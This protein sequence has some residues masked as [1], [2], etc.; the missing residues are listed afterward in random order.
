MMK[1][2]VDD[3]AAGGRG[4]G[5]CLA[6]VALARAMMHKMLENGGVVA[7]GSVIGAMNQATG[8]P[9]GHGLVAEADFQSGTHHPNGL[10]DAIDTRASF[11][12]KLYGNNSF[13][14]QIMGSQAVNIKGRPILWGVDADDFIAACILIVIAS[15]APF[16]ARKSASSTRRKM[17]NKL[18]SGDDSV[19]KSVLVK[20]PE[21]FFE[22]AAFSFGL[23][24]SIFFL[25]LA[26]DILDLPI[27]GGI[28]TAVVAVLFLKIA[29]FFVACDAMFK[30]LDACHQVLTERYAE[31]IGLVDLF[32]SVTGPLMMLAKI[33][34]GLFVFVCVAG[35]LARTGDN[36][37]NMF[38]SFV[39]VC[40]LGAFGFMGLAL[41]GIAQEYQ[42]AVDIIT[43]GLFKK[44]DE[45]EIQ[46]SGRNLRG[47]VIQVETR[48]TRLLTIDGV[49]V[50]IPNNSIPSSVVV[51]HS[52][53]K[54]TQVSAEML[55]SQKCKIEE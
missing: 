48:L 17:R 14:A 10:F 3:Q 43:E 26:V 22:S 33:V 32:N 42:S 44:D 54:F 5:L 50:T 27:V 18:D 21:A 8:L 1:G 55:I 2:Q 12:F 9:H 37:S 28:D 35:L 52:A 36:M 25:K 46:S 53:R 41:K 40:A 45:I 7:K 24:F 49:V 39:S 16:I 15:I 38:M 11:P 19:F 23:C 47:R 20:L 51:N 4:Q 34:L 29:F 6:A 31:P 30:V 13:L